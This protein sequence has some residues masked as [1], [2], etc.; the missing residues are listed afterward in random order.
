MV[1]APFSGRPVFS[2]Y[3]PLF[4]GP[5]ILT[6]ARVVVCSLVLGAGQLAAQVSDTSRC[7]SIVAAAKVDTQVVAIWVSAKRMDQ[8]PFLP[9]QANVIAT[10]VATT[11]VAPTPFRLTVFSGPVRPRFLRRVDTDTIPEL[12]APT[13]TGIYRYVTTR[14]KAVARR[15]VIR[16]SLVPGFDAAALEAIESASALKEFA[17]LPETQESM[18]VEIRF[19]LDSTAGARRLVLATFPRM[20]VVDAEPLRDNPRPAFPPEEQADTALTREVVLRF[21]VDRTGSP[22]LE[23]VELVRASSLAFARE[24]L[25]VLPKQRFTPARINGCPVAQVVLYPFTFLPSRPPL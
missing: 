3:P 13:L 15:E 2:F 10:A 8:W 9:G 23:T 1:R 19:D 21:V 17:Y 25:D 12:R 18:V 4:L 7:D 20:R 22:A 14:T 11:F 16:A 24:A 6:L 5:S